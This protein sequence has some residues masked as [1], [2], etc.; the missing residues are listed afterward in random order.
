MGLM[1]IM[2]KILVG[3]GESVLYSLLTL[4]LPNTA[5][6]GAGAGYTLCFSHLVGMQRALDLCLDTVICR[7]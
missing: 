4:R 3:E 6:V 2:D 5:T 7:I 1:E